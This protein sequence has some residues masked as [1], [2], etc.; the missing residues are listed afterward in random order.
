MSTKYYALVV[1]GLER[2]AWKNIRTRLEDVELIGEEQGRLLF[3][4][5]GEAR[6]LLYLRSVENVYIFVRNI[7]GLTRSRKSL[8]DIFRRVRSA[9]FETASRLHKQAHRS[10]GKK[11][12]TFKVISTKLGRHNFRRVDA[13]QAVESAISGQYGW[14]LSRQDPSLEIRIDLDEDNALLGLKL[15]NEIMRL[16]TYKVVNLPASL[17]P[18]VAYCMTLL[19]NPSPKDIFVDPMCGVGTIA[20]ERAMAE[21]YRKVIAGDVA[22]NIVRAARDNV[23]ASRKSVDLAVWDVSALSFKNNS[24]D[25]IVCNLP[26][27]RQIGSRARNQK[28]YSS[29]FRE[30]VRISRPGGRAILLTSERAL[31]LEIMGKYPSVYM[32]RYLKIDLLGIRAYI[33][34]LNLG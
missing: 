8:G 25:K 1:P 5:P 29:F 17:K 11:R 4:Y 16:R 20:I 9:D 12:L 34:V 28:L 14:R 23:E 21:P 13:Q 30:M 6:N 15:S 26:F 2:V 33:F 7:T 22:E 10:K 31:M 18:T 3:S 27:G 19:S 32:E 24:V